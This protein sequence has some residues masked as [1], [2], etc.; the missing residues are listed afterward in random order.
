VS[1]V[2]TAL[3]PSFLRD[4]WRIARK[5]LLIEFRT[6]SAFLAAAVFAVLSVVI[7][8]FTWDPTAIPAMD[9]APGCSG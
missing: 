2:S 9:L 7:F 5:D 1:D 6:R 8:R 4:A 3:P